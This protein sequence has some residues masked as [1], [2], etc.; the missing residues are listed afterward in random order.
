[1]IVSLPPRDPDLRRALALQRKFNKP[2][3]V[4]TSSQTAGK[5]P[6]GGPGGGSGGSV[7][8]TG[9]DN[10]IV[11]WDGTGNI[12]DS[13]WVIADTTNTMSI[14]QASAATALVSATNSSTT[15]ASIALYG[16]ASGATGAT[17]AI[18][19]VSG[20]SDNAAYAGAFLAG[21]TG[22][23]GN[24]AIQCVGALDCAEVAAPDTPPSGYV[25]SYYDT[26]GHLNYKDDTGANHGPIVDKG[27]SVCMIPLLP[28]IDN[29]TVADSTSDRATFVYLGRAWKSVASGATIKV[30][31][32]LTRVYQTGGAGPWAEVGIMRGTPTCAAN[33]TLDPVG[34]IDVSTAW[35]APTLPGNKTLSITTSAAIVKGDD[36]WLAVG[37]KTNVVGGTYEV[38]GVAPEEFG[39]GLSQT[40]A[41]SGALSAY[42]GTGVSITTTHNVPWAELWL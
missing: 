4:K 1:M 19:G 21:D 18:R 9:T 31:C 37:S 24:A 5:I 34:T 40:K 42:S 41:T 17:N 32:R 3:F 30:Q 15:D 13:G 11:R 10:H 39:G 29:T 16:I 23:G 14:S 33:A 36:L 27:R 20:S 28:K 7:N 2:Q 12:Q 6:S 38:R 25:R 22:S 26:S 35:A 8:G